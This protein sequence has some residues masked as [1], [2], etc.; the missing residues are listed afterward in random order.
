MKQVFIV[1]QVQAADQAADQSG[2]C[3]VSIVNHR[4]SNSDYVIVIV[5]VFERGDSVSYKLLL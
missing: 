4:I 2:A 3:N 5:S 1:G